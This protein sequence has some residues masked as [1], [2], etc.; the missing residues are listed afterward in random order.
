MDAGVL[1]EAVRADAGAPRVRARDGRVAAGAELG[2]R[3]FEGRSCS[4]DGTVRG[5]ARRRV[6]GADGRAGGAR[7]ARRRPAAA[8]V[9][10]LARRARRP[11][12]R[13]HAHRADGVRER[14][15]D[16]GVR[17]TVP[18][19]A[20]ARGRRPVARGA[21]ARR[22]GARA[23]LGRRGRSTTAATPPSIRIP[24]LVRTTLDLAGL[25][26]GPS[27]AIVV[28][29]QGHYDDLALR[30]ALDDRRGLHRRRRGG[31]ARVVAARSCSATRGS[32]TRS[33]RACTRRPGLDLGAGRQ[34]RDRG[35]GA[36]RSRRSA[37]RGRSYAASRRRRCDARR[38]TRCAA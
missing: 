10:R 11:R 23:R 34:R 2:P 3:R 7:R 6:R 37:R 13:R 19:R 4:T 22:A 25:G 38:A 14:R 5:L 32:T 9:P 33:S 18:A 28:A 26:I 24:E 21:R 36:R 31:E 27:T 8:A 35:R 20:A 17:G 1:A 12:P 30:A 15:R 29:T 16:G